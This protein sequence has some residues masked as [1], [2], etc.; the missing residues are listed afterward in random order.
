M[1]SDLKEILG[2]GLA[3]ADP[4]AAVSDALDAQEAQGGGLPDR[5]F[6]LSAGKAAGAMSQAALSVLG[7]RVAGGLV[8][9]KHANDVPEAVLRSRLEVLYAAHPEPDESGVEAAHRIAGLA[10]SLKKGDTLIVLLSGGASSLLADPAPPVELN[11]LKRLTSA[12]LHSGASIEEINAVR[13]HVSTLKGGGLAR[14]AAPART[15][16]LILSDVVGD[17]PAHIASGPTVADPGTLADARKILDTYSIVAPSSVAERLDN[18][19]ETPKSGDPVFDLVKNVVCGSGRSACEAAAGKA[20]ELGYLP[21]L[22]ST[23]VTGEASAE[24]DK[25][26]GRRRERRMPV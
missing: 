3:A 9:S 23:S 20:E 6:V 14:M 1:D 4:Q 18:G 22:L 19:P 13:K 7:E 10:E 2:A 26:P 24:S 21:L 5:V 12:L 11:D 8:V 15:L 25:I 17:D 16:S